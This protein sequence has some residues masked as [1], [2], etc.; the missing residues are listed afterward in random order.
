MYCCTLSGIPVPVFIS[1]IVNDLEISVDITYRKSRES[2]VIT[3]ILTT[4]LQNESCSSLSADK[5]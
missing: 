4:N 1:T 5:Q 3:V 2:S